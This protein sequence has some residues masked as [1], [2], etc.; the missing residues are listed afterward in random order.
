MYTII[1]VLILKTGLFLVPY[2]YNCFKPELIHLPPK[3]ALLSNT[4]IHIQCPCMPHPSYNR[5]TPSCYLYIA[6]LN[7]CYS[8]NNAYTVLPYSD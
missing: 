3:R 8:K 2:Y 6:V 7:G 4:T 1:I 5:S